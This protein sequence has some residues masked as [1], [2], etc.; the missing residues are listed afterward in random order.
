MDEPTYDPAAD[1][2][3]RSLAAATLEENP[4]DN[5]I[6]RAAAGDPSSYARD[7]VAQASRDKWDWARLKSGLEEVNADPA[8]YEQFKPGADLNEA[9]K[10]VR[11]GGKGLSMSQ[12]YR[13]NFMPFASLVGSSGTGDNRVVSLK[14]YQAAS[15]RFGK[16]EHTPADLHD[17][18]TFEHAQEADKAVKEARKSNS[19]ASNLALELGHLS[20]VGTEMAAAGKLIQGA[21]A[22]TKFLRAKPPAPAATPA[23]GKVPANPADAIKA[24]EGTYLGSAARKVPLTLMTPSLYVPMMQQN[25]VASG[26]AANDPSGFPNAIAYGYA[27]M[28]VLGQLT[29]GLGPGNRVAEVAKKG[30]AATLELQAIDALAS[31]VDSQLPK[32]RKLKAEGGY[33]NLDEY[34]KASRA[35]DNDKANEALRDTAVQAVAFGIFGAAHGRPKE[36]EGLV[37]SYLDATAALRK[38]G[39]TK[40][41]AAD[42]IQHLHDRLHDATDKTAYLTRDQARE[43][44]KFDS[45]GVEYKGPIKQYADALAEAFN[46]EPVPMA[47]AVGDRGVTALATTPKDAAAK[48]AAKPQPPEVASDATRTIDIKGHFDRNGNDIN[49]SAE[50][51]RSEVRAALAAGDAVTAWLDG[52]Q[53]RIVKAEN[54]LTDDR[55][56]NWGV[57]PFSTPKPGSKTGIEITKRVASDATSPKVEATPEQAPIAPGSPPE[58]KRPDPVQPPP[59]GSVRPV[60]TT[61][62]AKN[63]AV[64]EED[65]VAAWMRSKGVKPKTDAAPKEWVQPKSVTLSEAVKAKTHT[66]EARF[67]HVIRN[68][69]GEAVGDVRLVPRGD[70]LHIDWIGTRDAQGQPVASGESADSLGARNI[71]AVVKQIAAAHPAAKVLIGLRAGGAHKGQTRGI[72]LDK[73]RG[74]KGAA[75]DTTTTP[76]PR[77]VQAGAPKKGGLP[78]LGEI[79]EIKDPAG[80]TAYVFRAD[81]GRKGVTDNKAVATAAAEYAKAD[82]TNP[83]GALTRRVLA[84]FIK[85]VNGGSPETPVRTIEVRGETPQ[86]KADTV[87]RR[88]VGIWRTWADN[89]NG[90]VAIPAMERVIESAG[91]TRLGKVDET[92]PFDGAA[93]EALV[94]VSDGQAVKVVRSGWDGSYRFLKARVEPVASDASNAPKT[95]TVK[96]TAER[97]RLQAVW[98]LMDAAARRSKAGRDLRAELAAAGGDPGAKVEPVGEA[99]E[100]EVP[101]PEI[102]AQSIERS[103]LPRLAR[104]RLVMVLEGKTYQE[105]ADADGVS[106]SAVQKSIEGSAEKA[107]AFAKLKEF[108]P[109]TWGH[110]GSFREAAESIRTADA[111]RR[112]RRSD[113]VESEQDRDSR[114][115]NEEDAVR[116]HSKGLLDRLF[117][118]DRGS[119]VLVSSGSVDAVRRL[120]GAAPAGG[121]AKKGRLSQWWGG[122][123]PEVAR[124]HRGAM[125]REIAADAFDVENSVGDLKA[126]LALDKTPLESLSGAALES[127]NDYLAGGDPPAG[128]YSLGTIKALSALRSHVDRMTD[129]MI[130]AKAV[131][132]R[133]VPVLLKNKGVYLIRQY[134]IFDPADGPKLVERRNEEI[135]AWAE[136]RNLGTEVVNNMANHIADEYYREHQTHPPDGYVGGQMKALLSVDAKDPWTLAKRGDIPDPLRAFWGE[137]KDPVSNYVRSVTKQSHV[138]ANHLFLS[139][140]A[141]D[142]T[143]KWLFDNPTDAYRANPDGDFVTFK[144]KDGEST[145]PLNGKI[146]EKQAA[147]AFEEMYADKN[148]SGPMQLYMKMVATAKMSKVVLSHT[149]IERNFLSNVLLAVRNGWWAART[150]PD[151][152]KKIVDDTPEDRAYYRDLIERGIVRE[153]ISYQDFQK[154]IKDAGW[155]RLIESEKLGGNKPLDLF[156]VRSVRNFVRG[157]T[158]LYRAGDEVWKVYGYEIEKARYQKAGLSPEAAADKAAEVVRAT[159]PT[160]S[161]VPEGIRNLRRS[162][163]VSAFPS[164]AAEMVRTTK[165]A[166]VLGFRESRDANPEIRKIGYTRLAGILAA[167]TLPLAAMAIARN[168]VGVT[169]DQEEAFR[170]TLPEYQKNSA[171]L[172]TG[173][174]ADGTPRATDLSR[175][176]PHA[177]I[178]DPTRGIVLSIL[179][180]RSADKV[181]W[182]GAEEALKPFIGEELL[183][184]PIVDVARN[185][186]EAGGRVYNENDPALQV[187]SDATAHLAQPFVPGGY[188]PARRLVKSVIGSPEQKTGENYRPEEAVVENVLGS[189]VQ[190]V[191]TKDWL[192]RQGRGFDR[193]LSEANSKV[194]EVLGAK[195]VVS[196][197]EL[198]AAYERTEAARKKVFDELARDAD[199]AIKLGM[200]RAQ[201][202]DALKSAGVSEADARAVLVGQYRPHEAK[203]ASD[204]TPVMRQRAEFLRKRA[205]GK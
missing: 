112:V 21:G 147:E 199:A 183:V 165:N 60:E 148:L 69:S 136:G 70:A 142:A 141:S 130:A 116:E 171:L 175:F 72:E 103:G 152:F 46:P 80:N 200:T 110:F 190:E 76:K 118:D 42:Q 192:T 166:A 117:K 81:G 191:R 38:D 49:K 143:G 120:F 85:D 5:P 154:T 114:V 195:G 96:D 95:E 14:D 78:K 8:E 22:L 11:A 90:P 169:S 105:V 26:R 39:M 201:V 94:P 188:G 56:Q 19:F 108:D 73:A 176:D 84:D 128:N 186:K 135:A 82:T 61:P 109:A 115:E 106:A 151:A 1:N 47:E 193:S 137:V 131:P 149:G 34:L 12:A 53:I 121:S 2:P 33:G 139:R 184:R 52:K 150:L 10:K 164:F 83:E 140:V 123:L 202:V 178:A 20:Q 66:G 167:G 44:M 170:R 101:V 59:E 24:A 75:P 168:L 153:G 62:E 196:P 144:A 58:A 30:G 55:G 67:D 25:N 48:G 177:I 189:R 43:A 3:I 99:R 133:L 68:E 92:V 146:M 160:Y 40:K 88:A 35:G 63:E 113:T 16:G 174:S 198:V 127:I 93:H 203:L 181:A 65:P 9:R 155:D 87:A 32:Y 64:V 97:D 197:N 74:R 77:K 7:V 119:I 13:R 17:I 91:A 179:E 31:I 162:F 163:F 27:T 126:A 23:L 111:D 185:R 129:R 205:A 172:F 79:K 156:A 180:G 28:L 145:S 37:K 158:R 173:K 41:Q 157:A 194:N 89:P 71:A 124:T 6:R 100:T 18:A 50:S 102:M 132:A 86:D 45:S 104:D 159:A 107:G 187:A 36:A 182:R 54:M 138:L 15:N 98:G 122:K 29:K 134:E 51:V 204:A 161:L 4:D 57:T 125:E